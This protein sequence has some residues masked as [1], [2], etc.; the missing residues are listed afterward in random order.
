MAEGLCFDWFI[1]KIHQ[2]FESLPDFRSPRPALKYRIKDAALGAFSMFF[3]QSPSFLSYQQAMKQAQGKSN[4]ESLFG[5]NQIPTDNQI[6]N[7][8]DPIAPNP[9]YSIFSTSFER[10]ENQGYLETDR[11]FEGCFLLPIDGTEYFRSSKIH[12]ENGS[13]TPHKKGKVS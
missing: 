1:G 12:C 7:L 2:V 5:I 8:L 3:S 13:E 6:R 11:F 9:L 4:A 10:L